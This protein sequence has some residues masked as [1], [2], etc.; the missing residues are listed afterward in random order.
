MI[1]DE[2]WFIEINGYR[3][4]KINWIGCYIY[5]IYGID[6]YIYDEYKYCN[7]IY[8]SFYILF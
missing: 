4:N 5:F 1:W 3:C 2:F 7:L 8:L 6:I